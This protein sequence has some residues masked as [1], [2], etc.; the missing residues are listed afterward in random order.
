M[1]FHSTSFLVLLCA[2]FAVY[3]LIARWR[4]PRLWL[5]LL[6]SLGFYA[7]W[8]PLPLLLYLFAALVNAIAGR[9]ME[10]YPKDLAKRKTV[11][12][13]AVCT[14]VAV[15]VTY[16][17]LQLLLNSAGTIAGWLHLTWAPPQLGLSH[18]LGLS[19]LTFQAI[20][21]VVDVYWKHT[22][23]RRSLLHQLLFLTFFPRVVS[24]P[25]LRASDLLEKLDHRPTLT[26]IDGAQ[27]LFR[28]TQGLAKKLLLADVLG[29]SFVNPVFA[30][31]TGYSA[32]ECVIAAVGYTLQLYFDFS[33]YSDIAIGIAGLLGIKFPENFNKPYHATDLFSFWNRW[34]LTLSTW[35]RDY[36]YR[37]LGGNQGTKLQTL[38]NTMIV[39]SLGGLWHGGDWR[40]LIWGALHGVFLV[41]WRIWWWVAGK[42]KKGEAGVVRNV[43]GWLV[44][45]NCVVF[46]RIFFRADTM[47]LAIDMFRQ[48]G[49]VTTSLA[50]VSA[51][52]W[53]SLVACVVFYALPKPAF[54]KSQELFVRSPVLVRAALL[55]GLGLLVRQFSSIESQPYIYLQY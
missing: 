36:L 50:R 20:G 11:M 23:G 48:L 12:V 2:L 52:T 28:I 19:F 15:L 54:D 7:V 13:V 46:A 3:W 42:P 32:L 17:Y 5:L 31:P 35:L 41:L 39:M 47:T 8:N 53:G 43:I 27:A 24:G 6:A 51:L 44:M 38:R 26:S 30:N 4:L 37:P 1:S 45:F 22:S 33:G 55:I 16:K 18:P 25:I 10:R 40:F 49:T 14:H 21:Y 9:V 29:G 34:H